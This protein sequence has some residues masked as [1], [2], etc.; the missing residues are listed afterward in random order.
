LPLRAREGGSIFF[1]P[2]EE[3]KLSEYIIH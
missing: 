1:F 2:I 3:I